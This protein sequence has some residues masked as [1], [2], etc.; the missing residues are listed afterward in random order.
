MCGRYAILEE[1]DILEMREIIQEVNRKF[2]DRQKLVSRGEI[3]PTN[4]VPVLRSQADKV[5]LDVMKWGFP[6]FQK[7]SSVII[8][9]RSETAHEKRMFKD[10]FVS[11]RLILPS[12]GFYEWDRRLPKG[13]NKYYL[14]LPGRVMYMAGIYSQIQDT[15]GQA[16]DCFVILTREAAGAVADIHDRMPVIFPKNLIRS[17]LAADSDPLAL[18]DLSVAPEQA[19]LM[20]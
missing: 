6:H 20:V 17:W 7:K 13:Q 12:T 4:T 14:S 9:A 1:E 19:R 11:R 5:A 18:L 3:F 15:D 2:A 10:A 16:L 8:N